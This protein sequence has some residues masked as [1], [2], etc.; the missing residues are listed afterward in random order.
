M[1]IIAWVVNVLALLALTLFP[2]GAFSIT[3]VFVAVLLSATYAIATLRTPPR[4]AIAGPAAAGRAV[5]WATCAITVFLLLTLLPLPIWL[6]P[7]EGGRRHA[8]NLAV[9]E[10]I[11]TA[12]YQDF[13]P[14]AHYGYA[15]TRNRAGTAR[16][17][18][19]LL[20][21]MAA[22]LLS[23]RLTPRGKSA[24]LRVITLLGTLVA[25]AGIISLRYAPQ[26]DTLWWIFPVPNELPGP[27]ACFRNHNH[28]AGFMA[29][30]CPAALALLADDL[31]RGRPFRAAIS[32]IALAVMG[33]ALLLTLSRGAIL[34][35]GV[36][37][38]VSVLVLFAQRR[39]VPAG[40]LTILGCVALATLLLA[41]NPALHERLASLR[42][43]RDTASYQTRVSAW[44]AA[45]AGVPSYPLFGAG[46]NGFSLV[47]PQVR[48]QTHGGHRT[49]A[50]NEYVQGLV[51]GGFVGAMLA[52]LLAGACLRAA[53]PTWRDPAMHHVALAS[54][55]ALAAAATHAAFDYTLHIPLYAITAAALV[56]L[57]LSPASPPIEAGWRRVGAATPALLHVAAACLLAM[58]YGRQ[59]YSDSEFWLGNATMP[60]LAR[61][62]TW[63]P[64]SQFAWYFFGQRAAR[65]GTPES[66]LF[67]R[68]CYARAVAYDPKNYRL[69][70]HVGYERLELG[71]SA[72]AR[73]AFARVKELRDWMSVPE[74]EE[75]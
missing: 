69:W 9:S 68:Q 2:T 56:G 57:I 60:Q 13:I 31:A 65:L 20:G 63:T 23:A 42:H 15:L 53:V 33:R 32:L 36:G 30:L 21:T 1:S 54:I 71:D 4:T 49:H 61:A 25:L 12:V 18:L 29:L 40:G 39:W 38:G 52:L 17:T 46:A 51:D 8:Q 50:E 74:I 55:G 75:P 35:C 43:P 7:L 59:L 22:A 72:G 14:P 6:S 66:N 19:M 27:I 44:K 48:V 45:F 16:W 64:T 34:A 10:S 11:A 62:L 5:A 28:F 67:A 41:P 26:G 3:L 37:V 47:Y 24:F 73:E 58:A 70:D